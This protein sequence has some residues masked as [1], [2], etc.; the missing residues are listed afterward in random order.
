M[1]VLLHEVKPHRRLICN[2][3]HHVRYRIMHWNTAKLPV[4]NI[5]LSLHRNKHQETEELKTTNTALAGDTR[6][7]PCRTSVGAEDC[8]LAISTRSI[9]RSPHRHI[10]KQH[11]TTVST[12]TH[13]PGCNQNIAG[14]NKTI[15]NFKILA[16][17]IRL[18][19]TCQKISP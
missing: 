7:P 15:L 13:N 9:H 10:H 4:L 16:T 17:N 3:L 8:T 2:H 5:P 12:R 11:H 1:H 18:N 14:V 19:S 6:L